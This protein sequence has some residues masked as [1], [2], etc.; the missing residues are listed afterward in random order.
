[1]TTK[2]YLED[3]SEIKEMMQRSSRFLSLSGMSGIAAGLAALI[4]AY[5]AYQIAYNQPEYSSY[6]MLG[7]D[8]GI[9]RLLIIDGLAVMLVA[10]GAGYFFTARRAASQ[11][12]KVWDNTTKRLVINL[13]IPLAAGGIFV[14]I[15]LSK[16]IYGIVAPATL[17]FYGLA[18]VNASKYTLRDVRGLGMGQIILGLIATYDIGHGLF[19]WALGFGVLHIVYGSIM[20]F[21]YEK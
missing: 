6:Q 8:A 5:F 19:F 16:G 17:L 4:G 13:A 3:I 21:K 9:I 20:Y 1:M 18:L 11:G 12:Q 10:L 7:T 14:L 15:L 2:D